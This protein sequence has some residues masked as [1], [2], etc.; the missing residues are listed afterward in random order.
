MW[1]NRSKVIFISCVFI[2]SMVFIQLGAYALHL[3]FNWDIKIN[4]ILLCKNE[5]RSLGLYSVGYVLDLLVFYTGFFVIWK[6]IRQLFLSK[7]VFKKII[8]LR[9]GSLT[10][11]LNRNYSKEHQIITVINHKVPFA[12]TMGLIQPKVMLS[13]G[14]LNLLK[15]EEVEAVIHH[16]FYHKKHRDPLKTFLLSLFASVLWFIPILRWLQQRYKMIREVLADDHAINTMGTPVAL[17]SALLK[18]LKREKS[19]SMPFSFVSFADT[20]INYRIRKLVDPDTTVPLHPPLTPIVVSINVLLL[21]CTML[22]LV[23]S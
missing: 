11:E 12:F 17:G 14:L 10:E 8:I 3:L 2:A 18:L 5:M 7:K 21:L 15:K 13:T 9:D 22:V 6:T 19:I 16:E 1:E 23:L 20:A 4:V